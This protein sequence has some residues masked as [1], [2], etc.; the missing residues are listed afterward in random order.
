MELLSTLYPHQITSVE[1]CLERETT[2]CILADDMG[3]GKT[4]TT[5]GV[6]AR[7]Q[8]RTLIIVPKALMNQW[9]SELNKHLGIPSEDI[10][11]Y[12]GP[13]KRNWQSLPKFY[14]CN[15]FFSKIV[16]FQRKSLSSFG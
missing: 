10:C 2:G 3:L 12:H 11:I 8:L 16:K 6:L 4:V 9:V 14:S 13:K 1:W 15:I 7:N 5:C